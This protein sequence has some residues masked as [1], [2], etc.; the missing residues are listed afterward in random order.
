M[1]KKLTF[2]E[3]INRIAAETGASKKTVRDLLKEIG[4]LT[5]E[6]LKQNRRQRIQGLGYFR[7]KWTEPRKGRNPRTGETIEIPGHYKIIFK[8]ELS[9]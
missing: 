4:N 9:M 2:A 1:K 7:L 3:L 6:G 5:K 8:P